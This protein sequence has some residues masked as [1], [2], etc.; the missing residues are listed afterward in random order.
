[1]DNKAIP[2]TRSP[3]LLATVALKHDPFEERLKPVAQAEQA[4]AEVQVL[5]LEPQAV[6]FGKVAAKYPGAQETHWDEVPTVVAVIQQ[7]A[8]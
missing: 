8:A 5:Q 7:L 6:Q 1:M 2:G 4:E 3:E